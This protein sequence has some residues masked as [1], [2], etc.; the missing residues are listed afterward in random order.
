MI[1]LSCYF[2]QI[3]DQKHEHFPKTEKEAGSE[4]SP[5][6]E[7]GMELLILKTLFDIMV[8]MQIL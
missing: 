7:W 5:G 6:Q 3:H 2:V 4:K 1:F 8:I